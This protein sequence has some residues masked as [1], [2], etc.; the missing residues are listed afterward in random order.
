MIIIRA[1]VSL[2]SNVKFLKGFARNRIIFKTLPFLP[3]VLK[4]SALYSK[5]IG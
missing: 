2:D 3:L 4:F 5:L 1:V